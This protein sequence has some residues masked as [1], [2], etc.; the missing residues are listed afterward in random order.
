ME[1]RQPRGLLCRRRGRCRSQ[2]PTKCRSSQ[3]LIP[4]VTEFDAR[5]LEGFV[6]ALVELDVWPLKHPK[7]GETL[8]RHAVRPP[9]RPD[10]NRL[11]ERNGPD[12]QWGTLDGVND[13]G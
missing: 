13:D 10:S 12:S 1:P 9:Y 8:P 2:G 7:P 3:A 5:E 6:N 11:E 4:V